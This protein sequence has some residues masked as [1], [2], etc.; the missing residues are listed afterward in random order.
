MAANLLRVLLQ[1]EEDVAITTL[2]EE[3]HANEG[4]S[5]HCHGSI[6]GHAVIQRY[7][8]QGHERLYHNYFSESPNA[9]GIVG[10]SS[11]QKMTATM[12]M[13]A[14]RVSIDSVDDYVWIEESTAIES[15]SR[16]T[17][18]VVAIFGDEYLRSPNS[19][20]IAR[21]LA[22]GLA[23]TST[24]STS[25]SPKFVVSGAAREDVAGLA[26]FE[27]LDFFFIQ[28]SVIHFDVCL[29]SFQQH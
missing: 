25:S 1:E 11:L 16:F 18:A 6:P 24:L 29:N 17:K 3:Q 23:I 13:L 5:S 22:M 19:E 12:R 21:L 2:E 10:L 7:R 28:D 27:F 8:V 4:Q 26:I 15:L 20:D 14:Y 9:A